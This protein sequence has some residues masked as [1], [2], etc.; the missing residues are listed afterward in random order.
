M[1]F[2]VQGG[3]IV[4]VEPVQIKMDPQG[5]T[6]V[7][8]SCPLIDMLQGVP[9]DGIGNSLWIGTVYQWIAGFQALEK[10]RPIDKNGNPVP[11]HA[12]FV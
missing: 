4:K 10:K 6:V 11:C 5:V 7:V 12:V 8:L 9:M 3:A 2:L 1:H